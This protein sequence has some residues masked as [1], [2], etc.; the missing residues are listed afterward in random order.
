MHI[1]RPKNT[2]KGKVYTRTLLRDSYRA[3][4][5][6]VKHH[7]LANLSHCTP[8]EIRAIELA[9]RHKHQLEGLEQSLEN[10]LHLRQGASFGTIYL[11]HQVA[12]RI[13]VVAALGTGRQGQLALWQVLARALNQGSRLAAVRL[14]KNHAV[15][16]IIPLE[17]FNEDHLYANLGWLA[18]QQTALENSLFQR[19]YPQ[20]GPNLYLYDV[21]RSYLE[22]ACNQLAAWGYNRDGKKGKLQIVIGLLCDPVGNALSI[23]VFTGNTSDPKTFGQQIRKVAARFGG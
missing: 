22:G 9:L 17:P 15:G 14:A 3:A 13:G 4:D 7:T 10:P 5:G 1:D 8:E 23:E 11:L 21:T 18:E 6:K 16:Q 2:V 19:L 20:G 12:E